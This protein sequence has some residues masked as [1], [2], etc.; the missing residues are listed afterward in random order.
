MPETLQRAGH[1]PVF[2]EYGLWGAIIEPSTGNTRANYSD[3]LKSLSPPNGPL[4]I[5]IP[6]WQRRLVWEEDDVEKLIKTNSNLFGSAI[7]ASLESTNEMFLIDGLQ[8]FSTATAILYVLYDEVLKP[9]PNNP[10]AAQYFTSLSQQYQTKQPLY[11]Y[12]HDMLLNHGRTGI[13][14]SYSKLFQAV[15]KVIADGLSSTNVEN[16]AKTITRALM[17]RQIAVD[18]YYG[19]NEMSELIQTFLE[20][21]STGVVL[22]PVDLLRSHIIAQ[23]SNIG[24]SEADIEDFENSFTEIIQEGPAWINTLGTHMYY[25]MYT[26]E[27]FTMTSYGT[28]GVATSHVGHK[29][30]YIFPNWKNISKKTLDELFDYLQKMTDVAKERQLQD[31]TKHRYPYLA[32]ISPYKLPYAAIVWYFYKHH[33]LNF[34]RQKAIVETKLTAKNKAKKIGL[35]L[36]DFLEKTKEKKF[37]EIAIS[38]GFSES[39]AES[40]EAEAIQDAQDYVA[41][42]LKNNKEKN[43]LT[44]EL[45]LDP[46]HDLTP[47]EERKLKINENIREIDEEGEEFESL[48]SE[49]PDFL[50]GNLSTIDDCRLYYRAVIRRLI[51]GRVG[52][53]GYTLD[54]LMQERFNG[55]QKLSDSMNPDEAGDLGTDLGENWTKGKLGVL[56]MD[57]AKRIFNACLAPDKTGPADNFSPLIYH[58]KTGYYNI[59]HLIPESSAKKD[60]PGGKIIS[61]GYLP[62]FAPL[63]SDRNRNNLANPCSLKFRNGVYDSVMK[64]HPYCEWLVNTHVPP[65]QKD[66]TELVSGKHVLPIDNQAHLLE[67]DSSNLHNDRIQKIYDLLSSKI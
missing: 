52:R 46:E 33:Y 2:G 38:Q 56:K 11:K 7:L 62:N 18:P 8:R 45:T 9:T 27:D 31:D 25:V 57:Y 14:N 44:V 12:N 10:S 17:Q 58:N 21:N 60:L 55:I 23:A 37:T 28:G 16:F 41:K 3:A 34:L 63:E 19:F 15:K 29:P 20:I 67:A 43:D 40:F 66:A 47:T 26:E 4:G 22:K 24:W 6:P 35:E 51:D 30:E 48:F 39:D 42:L 61:P 32:E 54:K 13:R 53:S 49:L 1:T 5:I 36:D 50:G 64:I 65:H 59:D